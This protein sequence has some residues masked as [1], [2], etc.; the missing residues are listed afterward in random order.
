M[1]DLVPFVSPTA[2]Q[3]GEFTRPPDLPF[4]CSDADLLEAVQLW[5]IGA[6]ANEVAAKLGV[7]GQAV[8]HWTTAK[9]WKYLEECLRGE[10]RKVAHGQVTRLAA[11]ALGKL[12]TAIEMGD[13]V[14]GVDGE[15]K[16]HK[17][18]K[19]RDMAQIASIL[20]ERQTDMEERLGL[21]RNEDNLIDMRELA[22]GLRRYA[23]A[24]DVTP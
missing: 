19:A 14:I 22:E 8:K 16:G 4:T 13:P 7:Q 17:P 6:R 1:G 10:V 2:P 3:A 23:K 21:K 15:V 9:G 20:I 18:V 24:K 11:Q 12:E 5:L